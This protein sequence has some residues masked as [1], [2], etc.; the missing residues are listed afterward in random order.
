MDR[1]VRDLQAS[2]PT[3][4]IQKRA[5]VMHY[6][7]Y[8]GPTTATGRAV[9]AARTRAGSVQRHLLGRTS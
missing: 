3:A 9:L 1:G 2:G 4:V 8:R 6:S 5:E 7:A